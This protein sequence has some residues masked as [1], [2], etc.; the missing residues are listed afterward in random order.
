MTT[1]WVA[2]TLLTCAAIAVLVV[3]LVRARPVQDDGEQ[4]RLDVYRDRRR[5]IENERAA[6]RLGEAEA[7]RALDELIGD[8]ARQFPPPPGPGATPGSGAPRPSRSVRLVAAAVALAVPL[9]AIPLYQR[10]GAPEL[11]AMSADELR[12]GVSEAQVEAALSDLRRRVER[13][14]DDGEAWAMIAEANRYRGDH[15]AAASA[16]EQATRLLPP[17]ATLL[18]DYAETVALTRGGDFAG[19]PMAL[20]QQALKVAPMDLRANAMMGVALYRSG[21]LAESLGHLRIVRDNMPADAGEQGQAIAQLVTRVEQELAGNTTPGSGAGPHASPGGVAGGSTAGPAAGTSG[22]AAEPG[23]VAPRDA[24]PLI[25]GRVSVASSLGD[26]VPVDGTVFIIARA[27]QGPR[28][29]LAVARITAGQLPHEFTLADTDA[30]DPKRL[31]S[32]IDSVVV[33][34]RISASGNA[35]RASG[36]LFGVSEPLRPA[37][38]AQAVSLTIDQVVP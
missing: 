31:L 32:S 14:P 17:N 1:F 29:P 10:L 25:R 4:R 27:A 12:A 11:V 20:L 22:A 13:N 15:A 30:M 34:A 23:T 6:G 9:V 36:D 3:P 37:A 26:K 19:H 2:A 33:E 35:M 38:G 7:Q 18:T 28:M 21:R 16:F 8:V 5:E 24:T